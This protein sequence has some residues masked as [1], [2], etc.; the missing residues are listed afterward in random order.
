MPDAGLVTV[1]HVRALVYEGAISIDEARA[2]LGL[3][4]WNLPITQCLVEVVDGHLVPKR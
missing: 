4:P 2:R 3:A 1:A